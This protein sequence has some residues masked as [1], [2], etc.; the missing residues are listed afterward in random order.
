MTK[1]EAFAKIKHLSPEERLAF[2]RRLQRC[3]VVGSILGIGLVAMAIAGSR[4]PES[5][6]ASEQTRS[7]SLQEQHGLAHV[8]NLPVQQIEDLTHIFV[9]DPL[10][11][12]PTTVSSPSRSAKR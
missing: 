10:T 11:G 6:T 3:A 4:T 8:E 2:N 1:G 7:L 5:K 9:T 12:V